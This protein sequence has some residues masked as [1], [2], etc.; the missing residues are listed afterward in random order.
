MVVHV[1]KLEC[2]AIT[3]VDGCRLDALDLWCLWRLL[4]I[5]W[6][7]FV[8]NAEVWTI[9]AQHISLFGHITQLDDNADVICSHMK[10]WN[11]VMNAMEWSKKEE[12]VA[13]QAL[14]HLQP[15]CSLLAAV[16]SSGRSQ[17]ILINKVQDYCYDNMNFLKIFSKIIQLFYRS[18]TR[19]Q[20]L[21]DVANCSQGDEQ[22][23]SSLYENMYVKS[24]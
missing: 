9:Q 12:L 18:K 13:D 1:L 24:I 6:Y 7:Q 15:Y 22:Q 19:L 20:Y 4:G 11:T 21:T 17:L 16:T 23:C 2:W 3:E 8:S 10:V 5:K 14:K